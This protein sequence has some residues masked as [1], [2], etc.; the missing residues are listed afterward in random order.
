ME[1]QKEGLLHKIRWTGRGREGH[2]EQLGAVSAG[3]VI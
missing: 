1:K 3:A 2:P